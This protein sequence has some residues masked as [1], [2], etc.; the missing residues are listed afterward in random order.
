MFMVF[1]Q[2]LADIYIQFTIFTLLLKLVDKPMVKKI[3]DAPNVEEALVLKKQLIK[4]RK[5]FSIFFIIFIF[6]VPII[7]TL[8][9]FK[10]LD[11]ASAIIA[12]SNFA[13][14]VFM[15]ICV[16]IFL[17]YANKHHKIIGNLSIMKADEF[18]ATGE[19][20]V[21]YLRGFDSDI[22]NKKKVDEKDFSEDIL[23]KVVLK[24][25]ELPLVAVGMT[26]EVE[27][28]LG[29]KRVYVIDETWKQGVLDLMRH[30]EKI[31]YRVNDR[32]S[33]IWEIKSSLEMYDKCVFVVDDLLRYHKVKTVLSDTLAL[34]DIPPSEFES[35][36]LEYDSRR[37]YFTS[38]NKM[39]PFEGKLSDYCQMVGVSPS[40][41]SK[42]DLKDEDKPFYLRPFFVFLAILA[43]V[44]GIVTLAL[45]IQSRL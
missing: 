45:L 29:G 24:G 23:S 14:I 8:L 36:P 44:R 39:I 5:K 3:H 27:C 25:L 16:P 13:K 42:S 15:I 7:E 34:P 22:Y 43:A 38:D 37:F 4:K 10:P 41:V 1:F 21:L 28:P 20:Y 26:K 11:S 35:L 12:Y 33:C 31:V 2:I 30:A 6:A 40:S 17:D 32:D 9:L 18:L 19:K